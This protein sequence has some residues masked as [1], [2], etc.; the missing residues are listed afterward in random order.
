MLHHTLFDLTGQ[1]IMVTGGGTGL[2]QRFAEAVA[3]AGATVIVCARRQDKLA[4][5]VQ[6]IQDAGG[7]AHALALDLTS[8][9]SI[10]ECVD[11]ARAISSVTV[12][13]NNAGVGTDVLLKDLEVSSWDTAFDTNLKGCWLLARAFV[14]HWIA[15]ERP[16]NVINIGSVLATSVQMGTAAYSAAKAGLIQLTKAMSYEWA[17]HNVRV[18]A[19]NPGYYQTELAQEFLNS[20]Y[21]QKLVKRI[22]Q[23]RL[24]DPR[25]LDGAIILLASDASAYMTGSVI[26]VD[27]GLGLATV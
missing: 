2:G 4:D 21:G 12:L 27:G 7:V 19:I 26:Q 20:P 24:G 22:P 3:A 18:N 10:T 11:A 8:E 13:V 1:T 14:N 9:A 5:T 15:D 17:R 16:G 23:R 25:D 6:R